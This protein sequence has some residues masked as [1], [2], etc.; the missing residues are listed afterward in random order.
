VFESSRG[1]DGFVRIEPS[2]QLTADTQGTI[3]EARRLHRKVDR[4]NL[5]IKV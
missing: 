4:P 3:Q 5:M 2:P 1:A